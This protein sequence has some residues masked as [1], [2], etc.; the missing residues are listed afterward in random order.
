MP[1]PGAAEALGI[2]ALPGLLAARGSGGAQPHSGGIHF[3]FDSDA[4][5]AACVKVSEFAHA[6]YAAAALTMPAGRRLEEH[7][8][9]RRP[10]LLLVGREISVFRQ[11][12]F[13]DQ[14]VDRLAQLLP[15]RHLLP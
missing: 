3:Q 14:L 1:V 7:L 12:H 11:V 15:G 13:R 2:N 9:D 8:P 6:R 5:Q 4:S 10:R